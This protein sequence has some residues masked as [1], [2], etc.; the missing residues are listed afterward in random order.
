MF[1]FTAL[2][3]AWRGEGLVSRMFKDFQEMLGGV[4]EMLS[5]TCSAL[6]GGA[7]EE[8]REKMRALDKE[9]NKAERKIRRQ[10]VE[11]LTVRTGVD[12]EASL[13]LMSIVKDAERLGDY[14]RNVFAAAGQFPGALSQPRYAT[15][16]E[17]LTGQVEGLLADTRK[18]IAE[19]DEDLA[20][21]VM[22]REGAVKAAAD[23]LLREVSADTLP[24][25]QTVTLTLMAWYFRRLAAHTANIASSVVNPVEWLDYKARGA[26]E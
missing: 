15:A 22:E 26:K 18:A 8:A 20:T 16:I 21:R 19:S 17:G 3:K 1:D 12:V 13:V 10:I 14:A 5:I 7:T 2:I 6:N 25:S 4:V 24:S 11:H 23:A 9:V